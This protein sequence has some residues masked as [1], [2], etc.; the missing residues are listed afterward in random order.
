[1]SASRRS[2][3]GFI[4]SMLV[5]IA[6]ALPSRA[7]A[8]GG[9]TFEL[10]ADATSAYR[11]RL[12]DGSQILATAGQGYRAKSDAKA[13]IERIRSELGRLTFETYED[14]GHRFRWRLKSRNGQVVAA[15]SRGYDAKAD[16][17]AAVERIRT[18]AKDATVVDAS[19]RR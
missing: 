2:F 18:G 9:L 13:S 11:W 1:M 16:V 8:A 10:Y 19:S 4:A 17:D 14:A 6:L 12:E 3:L 5:V 7:R 15:S